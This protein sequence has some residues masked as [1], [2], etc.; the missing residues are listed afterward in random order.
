MRVC[1]LP[2]VT[3]ILWISMRCSATN[4]CLDWLRSTVDRAGL[5]VVRLGGVTEQ[6]PNSGPA[7]GSAEPAPVAVL[8]Q[9]PLQRPHQQI[10]LGCVAVDELQPCIGLSAAGL[11]L[12][13]LLCT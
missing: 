10:A 7:S 5:D 13:A 6:G 3:P 4:G 9:R 2:P 8:G 11:E 1:T 12:F